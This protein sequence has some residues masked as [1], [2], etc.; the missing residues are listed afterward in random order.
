MEHT[1][2]TMQLLF[3][4][5]T[6]FF[7]VVGSVAMAKSEWRPGYCF[8]CYENLNSFHVKY[9]SIKIYHWILLRGNHFAMLRSPL[10]AMTRENQM[11]VQMASQQS[12]MLRAAKPFFVVEERLD[13]KDELFNT[14]TMERGILSTIL[15]TS[16]VLQ[17]QMHHGGAMGLML[18]CC[19]FS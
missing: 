4:N 18:P 7:A 2:S 15:S 19:L 6:V 5:A 9:T 17:N 11:K 14:T 3:F 8:W 10:L 12:Q 1:I 13:T 16:Y